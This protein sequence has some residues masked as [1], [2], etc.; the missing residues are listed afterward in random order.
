MM[1]RQLFN[2]CLIATLTVSLCTL[3]FVRNQSAFLVIENLGFD[4]ITAHVCDQ[5]IISKNVASINLFE[6][7]EGGLFFKVTRQG[8]ENCRSAE[9]YIPAGSDLIIAKIYSENKN[10]DLAITG[11]VYGETR[12]NR[13]LSALLYCQ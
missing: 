2:I 12:F 8:L 4:Q 1:I 9:I 3:Y 5:K 7:C 6:A 10:L 13:E 11:K